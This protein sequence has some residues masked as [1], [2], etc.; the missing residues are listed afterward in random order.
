VIAAFSVSSARILA[1]SAA[2]LG[3][4]VGDRPQPLCLADQSPAESDARH[5]LDRIVV[6]GHSAAALL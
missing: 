1:G 4:L 6:D 5:H 3:N 2:C